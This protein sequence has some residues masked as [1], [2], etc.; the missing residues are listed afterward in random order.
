MPLYL[1]NTLIGG[2]NV[3]FNATEGGGSGSGEIETCTVTINIQPTDHLKSF[4][5]TC[6]E[7]GQILPKII[8]YDNYFGG[9]KLTDIAN[10][11][12]LNNVI[13]DSA[14][15]VVSEYSMHGLSIDGGI[16][17]IFSP[18]GAGYVLLAPTTAGAHGII[19]IYDND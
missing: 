18:P 19:N 10:G 12:T 14:I 17:E 1:G 6:Y 9:I 13:C 15:I 3:S 8:L 4:S 5:C 16:T 11:I 7:N 2:T